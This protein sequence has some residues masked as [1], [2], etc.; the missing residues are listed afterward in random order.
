MADELKALLDKSPEDFNKTYLAAHTLKITN[1]RKAIAAVLA[2]K[3]YIK[4]TLSDYNKKREELSNF[5]L[6]SEITRNLTAEDSRKMKE[7]YTFM[8]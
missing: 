3:V 8:N 2:C 4:P 5:L 6:N 7:R 1:L